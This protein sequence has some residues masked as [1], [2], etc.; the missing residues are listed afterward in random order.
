MALRSFAGLVYLFLY[1]PILVLVIYSF[2]RSV[3]TAKWLGF[4]PRWYGQVLRDHELIESARN[5]L[6]VAGVTTLAATVKG[7]ALMIGERVKR[8]VLGL[9]RDNALKICVQ[10]G[11]SLSWNRKNKVEINIGKA[12]APGGGEGVSAVLDA[13]A[14]AQ[15]TQEALVR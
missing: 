8:D 15:H 1:A 11:K 9:E 5:S 10:I 2:N 13:V 4:T 7:C 6:L 3:Q 12:G 14:A